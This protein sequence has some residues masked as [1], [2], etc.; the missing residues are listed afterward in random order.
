MSVSNNEQ[1]W[2][3]RFKASLGVAPKPNFDQWCQRHPDAIAELSGPRT[4]LP[5]KAI[6]LTNGRTLWKIAASILLVSGAVWIFADNQNLGP[7]AFA[8]GVPGIDNVQ[9]MTWTEVFFERVTSV[10]KQRTWIEQTRVK[11]K[12]LHPGKYRK[13]VF[14]QAGKP[15]SISITDLQSNRQLILKPKEKTAVLQVPSRGAEDIRGPFAWVGDEIRMNKVNGGTAVTS[16][17]LVGQRKLG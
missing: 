1:D 6:S 2:E 17:S 12:Y 13:T 4:T 16:V 14:D 5:P 15:E 7:N 9:G 8:Q 11:N 3:T 10:D